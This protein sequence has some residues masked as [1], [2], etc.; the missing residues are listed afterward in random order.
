MTSSLCP[1]LLSQLRSGHDG[2]W[3]AAARVIGAFG[4]NSP[5]GRAA[6]RQLGAMPLLADVLGNG[7]RAPI[8][9]QEAAVVAVRGLLT[10]GYNDAYAAETGCFPNI[11]AGLASVLREFLCSYYFVIYC[12]LATLPSSL[13]L[14]ILYVPGN[15]LLF[16]PP[17][18]CTDPIPS[19]I[20]AEKGSTSAQ[21]SCGQAFADLCIGRKRAMC[22][23]MLDANCSGLFVR[24]I[25]NT[26]NKSDNLRLVLVACLQRL[27]SVCPTDPRLLAP[28][29]QRVLQ[30]NAYPIDPVV[31]L[32]ASPTKL[33]ASPTKLGASPT[34]LDS[35]ATFLASP[36]KSESPCFV[37]Q[38]RSCLAYFACLCFGA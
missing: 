24:A 19:V 25:N 34:K 12:L 30:S 1:A 14:C 8:E 4:G 10:A 20:I 23:V 38:I 26:K 9:Q 11:V 36:T 17:C 22:N 6:L 15:I 29:V 31:A 32:A 28:D 3:S 21:L 7:S 5:E 13:G 2:A 18:M 16:V 27:F 35:S 37:V 33:G